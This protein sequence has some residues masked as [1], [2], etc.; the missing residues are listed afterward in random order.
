MT[1]LAVNLSTRVQGSSCRSVA[2]ICMNP[3]FSYP[4]LLRRP[5]GFCQRSWQP[6]RGGD[7]PDVT[8]HCLGWHSFGRDHQLAKPPFDAR[9]AGGVKPGSCK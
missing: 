8:Y 2:A 5:G 9:H 4:L 1:I 3:E 6:A 7:L